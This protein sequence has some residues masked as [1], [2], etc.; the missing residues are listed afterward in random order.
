LPRT[1]IINDLNAGVEFESSIASKPIFHRRKR[2]S[3]VVQSVDGSRGDARRAL[4][5]RNSYPYTLDEPDFL[6]QMFGAG[7][8][9][10][11]ASRERSRLFARAHRAIKSADR[12][13]NT[14][15][16]DREEQMASA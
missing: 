2:A 14:S 1:S 16:V 15:M 5:R 8:A 7:E 6:R 4:G 11:Q 10:L 9:D 13:Y 3:N 12:D